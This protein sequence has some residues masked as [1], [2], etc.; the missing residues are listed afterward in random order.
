MAKR[1]EMK[2]GRIYEADNGRLICH[3][4]AGMSARFTGRDISGK[5]IILMNDADAIVWEIDVGSPMTCEK[6]CT[7]HI[8]ERNA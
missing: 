8:L 1:Y 5:R 4:C 6:G 7:T 2:E 3:K